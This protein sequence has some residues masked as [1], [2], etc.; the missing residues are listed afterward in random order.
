MSGRDLN[1]REGGDDGVSKCF[2]AW[3]LF[4]L[5]TKRSRGRENG[6]KRP[7]LYALFYLLPQGRPTIS[8]FSIHLLVVR[9]IMLLCGAVGKHE[10]GGE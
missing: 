6:K 8:S 7:Y 3:L 4:A 2:F 5:P 10:A 9:V 1:V